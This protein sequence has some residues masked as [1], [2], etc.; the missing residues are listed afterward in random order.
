M[1]CEFSYESPSELRIKL[2]KIAGIKLSDGTTLSSLKLAWRSQIFNKVSQGFRHCM[3]ID[4]KQKV[5]PETTVV[6]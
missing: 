1:F 4:Q 3:R 5:I 2:S 6:L